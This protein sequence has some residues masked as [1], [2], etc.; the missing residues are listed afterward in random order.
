MRENFSITKTTK[1]GPSIN[2]LPFLKIKEHVLGK[3]Y[4]LSL[5]FVGRDL[6]RR[7]NKEYKGKDKP[8][9]ILSFP[10]S[11]TEGEIVIN[12]HKAKSEASSFE[13]TPRQHLLF[14]FI[15]GV[16]HLKGMQHSATMEVEEQR[17]L[18]KFS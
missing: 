17:L 2:G 5:A 8:T 9:N 16:L 14:L 11:K 3:K 4:E 18:K 10:L 15:H 7:L 13:Q 1:K 6:S 12:H